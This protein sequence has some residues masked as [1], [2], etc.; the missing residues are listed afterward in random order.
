MS[1][2]PENQDI[3]DKY[4]AHYRAS[5]AS[6]RM[7]ESCL[8]TFFGYKDKDYFNYDGH[9]FD[10]TTEVLIDYF[11]YL[12]NLKTITLQTKKNKWRILVSFLKY[13]MEY[14]QKYDFIVVIPRFSIKWGNKHPKSSVD[15]NAVMT[16]AEV[17]KVLNYFKIRNWKY[18]IIF[19]MFCRMG[20]K[21]RRGSK[22]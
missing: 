7:R 19:P 22:C 11:D 4:L 15:R 9:V 16:E 12:K 13:T 20:S 17:E 3:V 2:R 10:I 8:N 14:Y 6:V 21:E 1:K 18:Y 5:K